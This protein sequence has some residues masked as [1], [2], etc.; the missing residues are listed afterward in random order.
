MQKAVATGLAKAQHS[1]GQQSKETSVTVLG[2]WAEGSVF[3]ELVIPTRLFED[4][5]VRVATEWSFRC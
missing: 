3:F 1:V 5:V 2:G 4:L